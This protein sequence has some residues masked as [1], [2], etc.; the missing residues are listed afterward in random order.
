MCADIFLLASSMI[1]SAMVLDK[2]WGNDE[3]LYGK[4]DELLRLC[5]VYVD[6]FLIAG[7]ESNPGWEQRKQELKDLYR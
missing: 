1:E 4:N 6:D 3:F 7:P 5:Y 2:M